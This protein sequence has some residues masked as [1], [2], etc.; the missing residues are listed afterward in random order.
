MKRYS[1]QS[2]IIDQKKL[3]NLKVAVC[4]LGG[5]GSITAFELVALG[6]GDILLVDKDEVSLTDLN[7]QI[8]Y[9]E[10][11]IG[12]QKAKIAVKRL[13]DFNSDI[14]IKGINSDISRVDF[15]D[16]DVVFSCLDNWKSRFVLDEK[17]HK[18]DFAI[19]HGSVNKFKG[20][21]YV[22]YFKRNPCFKEIFKISKHKEKTQITC[23]VC[24]MVSSIMIA[25]FLNLIN[26]RNVFNQL[27][28]ID[29]EK[30]KIEVIR[31]ESKIN[32]RG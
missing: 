27:T 21:V 20:I 5:L 3:N 1:R 15:S 30:P 8:L 28:V 10:K 12:K 4:G 14:K 18:E 16:R 22:H 32:K 7:R 24:S 9:G 6:V 25:R 13:R 2:K 29:A 26:G 11:D 17:S 23:H 19:I 31:V